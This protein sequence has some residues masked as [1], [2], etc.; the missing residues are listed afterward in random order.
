M[1][2]GGGADEA[3]GAVL[4]GADVLMMNYVAVPT[5]KRLMICCS[6]CQIGISRGIQVALVLYFIKESL[7]YFICGRKPGVG[8]LKKA[9]QSMKISNL[10]GRAFG[11]MGLAAA[12][13]E[14]D[15]SASSPLSESESLLSE[16]SEESLGD[17]NIHV[18]SILR[19]DFISSSKRYVQCLI[20]F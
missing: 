17:C 15:F 8:G 14:L 16:E 10:V 20:I 11:T 3:G 12:T 18:G 7:K 2:G 19:D 1:D 9:D 13:L 5:L 4:V 6:R